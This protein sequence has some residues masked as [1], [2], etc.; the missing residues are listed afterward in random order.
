[1]SD[2]PEKIRMKRE[3]RH[4][5]LNAK[6]LV[7]FQAIDSD[8]TEYIRSDLVPK[9]MPIESAPRNSSRILVGFFNSENNWIVREA[10][11]R[12][13]HEDALPKQ[14]HWCYDG[15]GVLLDASIHSIGAKYWM[16]LSKAPNE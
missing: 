10:W 3:M 16:P 15:T 12:L 2:M 9:W 8:A 13:P 4:D 6:R 11:W 5:D 7:M 1:M 14:C